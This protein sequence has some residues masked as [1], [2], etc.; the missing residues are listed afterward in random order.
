MPERD[1][2]KELAKVDKQL[3][4]L[5]D[6]ELR[7]P[8]PT[9]PAKEKHRANR[10]AARLHGSRARRRRSA[11]MRVCCSPSHSVSRSS[12]GPT[13]HAA[14]SDCSAISAPSPRWLRAACGRRSGRS[15]I[16]R[17]NRTRCRCSS[18]SRGSCSAPWTCCRESGTGSRIRVISIH[19]AALRTCRR[20]RNR[21]S[22]LQ[23]SSRRR[24]RRAHS[25][26]PGSNPPL[27][28]SRPHPSPRPDPGWRLA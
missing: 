19:G 22:S 28:S 3:S 11:C 17:A 7:G 1:W 24:L 23:Q 9:A 12:S 2:D 10:R 5:S 26:Q 25:L 4:S 21:R 18:C 16:A 15:A 14:G 20:H 27:G 6:D 8:A 13:T